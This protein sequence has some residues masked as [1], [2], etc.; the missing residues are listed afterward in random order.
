M[1]LTPSWPYTNKTASTH[2]ITPVSIK[3]VTNYGPVVNTSDT[4]SAQNRTCPAGWGER[5]TYTCKA[6]KKVNS[7]MVNY[8]PGKVPDGVQYGVRVDEARRLTDDNGYVAYDE[9]IVM[10]LT[11]RHPLDGN[12]DNAVVTEVFNRLIGALQRDDGTYRFDDLMQSA[13]MP[14]TD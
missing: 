2:T 12:I 13:L 8:N 14:T 9:P 3:P 7:L 11:V 4:Y 5:I 1:P 6:I 10:Y